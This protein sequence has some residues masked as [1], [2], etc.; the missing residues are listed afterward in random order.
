VVGRRPYDIGDRIVIS[1]KASD[2][3]PSMGMSWIVEGKAKLEAFFE[4]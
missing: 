4:S 1:D 2:Q 3:V